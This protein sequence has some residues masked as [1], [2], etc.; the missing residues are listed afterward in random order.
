MYLL[1]ASLWILPILLITCPKYLENGVKYKPGNGKEIGYTCYA[2]ELNNKNETM[3]WLTKLQFEL[4]L[5]N[6]IALLLIMVSS[7]LVIWFSFKT[8]VREQS[9]VRETIY[10]G[11]AIEKAREKTLYKTA[12]IFCMPYI[13]LA[14]RIYIYGRTE[15]TDIPFGLGTCILLHNLQFCTHFLVYAVIHKDYYSAYYDVL[16][17]IKLYAQIPQCTSSMCR[18][19]QRQ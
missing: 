2:V 3:V 4:N 16:K 19:G 5:F 7:I 12:A 8:E 10:F 17:I 9:R 11:K 14:L 15:I 1:V 18:K 13:V 6:D